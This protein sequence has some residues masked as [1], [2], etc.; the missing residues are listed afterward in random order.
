M[1]QDGCQAH[2]VCVERETDMYGIDCPRICPIICDDSQ[3]MVGG[4][5]PL[6]EDDLQWKMTFS[7]RRPLLDPCMLPTPFCGIFD[8]SETKFEN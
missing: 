5:Q 7:G 1:K 3:V 2:D 4:G 6:V 8:L